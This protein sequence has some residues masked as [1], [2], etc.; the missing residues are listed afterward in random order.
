MRIAV[1][2]AGG[3]GGY[4]GGLL[5]RAGK[6]S[7]SSPAAPAHWGLGLPRVKS[8]DLSLLAS[9]RSRPK[10]SCPACPA[11]TGQ[12]RLRRHSP[13]PLHRTLLDERE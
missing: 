6:T 4:F 9:L 2:G 1:V 8:C 11:P 3:T 5:A 13:C 10:C 12:R 7:P